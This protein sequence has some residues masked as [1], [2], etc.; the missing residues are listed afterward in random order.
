M[1]VYFAYGSNMNVEAMRLRC[2]KSRALG[3]ARLVRH[4]FFIMSSGHAS[5]QRDP[6]M[7]VHGV[8]Y[9]LALS[10][11]P[12]LDR[13]EEIGRGLYTKMIQPVLRADAAPVRALLYIGCDRTAGIA[14]PDYMAEVVAAARAWTMPAAYITQL[15]TF[16]AEKALMNDVASRRRAALTKTL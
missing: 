13:Y 8:L 4:R 1:P 10:D 15:E 7:D 3:R 16:A 6:R 12:A 11:V 5:V 14:R 9:D 2:P